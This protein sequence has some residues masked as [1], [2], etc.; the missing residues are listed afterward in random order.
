M[1]QGLAFGPMSGS[2]SFATGSCRQQ[3]GHVRYAPKAEAITEHR[4][5]THK[6]SLM[7]AGFT[8]V[9]YAPVAT[10]FRTHRHD[11]M[12]HEQSSKT[13]GQV[14]MKSDLHQRRSGFSSAVYLE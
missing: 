9:R 2:G 13:G 6:S 1:R 8:S 4:A 3:A 7:G 12:R 11:A 10:K 5:R 14:L